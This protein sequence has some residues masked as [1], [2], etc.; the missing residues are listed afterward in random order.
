MS[1][2][3]D[4]DRLEDLGYDR[5]M[6]QEALATS[7]GNLN[8]AIKL[9]NN[10]TG[11]DA[12]IQ[13]VWRTEVKGDFEAGLGPKGC[14]MQR[15]ENRALLKTPLYCSVGMPIVRD[16][17]IFYQVHAIL[18]SG[19]KFIR[20]RRYSSFL[21]LWKQL[22]YGTLSHFKST[23]PLAIPAFL[24]TEAAAEARRDGLD[25]WIREFTLDETIM[26]QTDTARLLLYDFLSI[27][28]HTEAVL[29]EGGDSWSKSTVNPFAMTNDSSSGS[30]KESARGPRTG[31]TR[32]MPAN[33]P[34]VFDT[35]AEKA[36]TSL[37]NISH[38]PMLEPN[39]CPFESILTKLPFRV[40][41]CATA[42][43]V[44]TEKT[45]REYLDRE[46][47]KDN[48]RE[49]LAKDFRRDRI[50]I[51]KVR[52]EGSN[53]SLE[54]ILSKLS[55]EIETVL[56]GRGRPG[57]KKDCDINRAFCED[58]LRRISRTE[59]AYLSHLT[60]SEIIKEKEDKPV[61]LVPVSDLAEPLKIVISLKIR[62]EMGERSSL[63][64]CGTTGTSD[65]TSPSAKGTSSKTDTATNDDFAV[66]VELQGTTTF[67]V[68]D[69]LSENLDTLCQVKCH[70]RRTVFGMAAVVPEIGGGGDVCVLTTKAGK[71][72]VALT[73]NFD[74]TREDWRNSGT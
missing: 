18:K 38:I 60:F 32:S 51:N 66:Q 20:M 54:H 12:A 62:N 57:L 53:T 50:I 6:A 45:T 16:G 7:Q 33:G 24:F 52:L 46:L 41:V 25:E 8:E 44:L 39:P 15:A 22:P 11:D 42:G 29:E 5:K 21:S 23:F 1:A 2:V 28:P 37:L 19:K 61:V 9:L 49:Q 47:G 30:S 71:A 26:I 58:L 64:S 3:T 68:N 17:V 35:D 14:N 31:P 70:Y 73:K 65:S 72:W 40:P 56:L 59:S 55:S 4:I 43:Q 34:L 27:N 10:A 74:T 69:P 36:S 63:T 13:G 48:S 67:R